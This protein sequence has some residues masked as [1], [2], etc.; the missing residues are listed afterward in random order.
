MIRHHGD[1]PLTFRL[2]FSPQ[3][4]RPKIGESGTPWPPSPTHVGI[5]R[6]FWE[7]GGLGKGV[8]PAPAENSV[9]NN[10]TH[11]MW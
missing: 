1:Q 10:Y 4:F 6:R 11:A 9:R 8:E 5:A 2:L 7:V 3:E